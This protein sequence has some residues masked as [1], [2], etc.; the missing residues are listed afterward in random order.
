[1]YSEEEINIRDWFLV[2]ESETRLKT[3]FRENGQLC[4]QSCDIEFI[5]LGKVCHKIQITPREIPTL[6][7]TFVQ[8]IDFAWLSNFKPFSWHM[9]I[10]MYSNWQ[11][12][13]IQNYNM[14]TQDWTK[15]INC[16]HRL[17]VNAHSPIFY[18][19]FE[20]GIIFHWFT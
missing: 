10:I 15:R 14:V 1:M 16:K 13:V 8:L 20:V 17:I 19:T 3:G 5:N 18:G 7:I 2:E 4:R 12:Y 6:H 9:H 11:Y